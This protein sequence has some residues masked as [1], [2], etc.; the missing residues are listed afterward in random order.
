M[1]SAETRRHVRRSAERAFASTEVYDLRRADGAN[2]RSALEAEAPQMPPQ[3]SSAAGMVDAA[4]NRARQAVA[5]AQEGSRAAGS[6]SSRV[7][8]VLD[9]V[10]QP[11]RTIV[12]RRM[13]ALEERENGLG[14]LLTPPGG[15]MARAAAQTGRNAAAAASTTTRISAGARAPAAA[16]T[17]TTLL[18]G[19]RHFTAAASSD[20][21]S[22]DSSDG[23]SDSGDSDSMVGGADAFARRFPPRRSAAAGG[24]RTTTPSLRGDAASSDSGAR[25]TPFA[26]PSVSLSRASRTL[27]LMRQRA[28]MLQLVLELSRQ[29]LELNLQ[30]MRMEEELEL[31]VAL[32]RSLAGDDGVGAGPVKPKG[33]TEGEIEEAA[34]RQRYSA[35]VAIDRKA[36]GRA[37]CL[38]GGAECVICQAGLLPHESVRLLQCRHT[39]HVDCI[40]NW[41][42]RSTC[43]PLCRSCVESPDAAE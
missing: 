13:A 34:P 15:A 33:M 2:A 5:D 43:C 19:R 4:I 41:L 25:L 6:L 23:G 30:R 11:E 42:S 29:E 18:T 3:R 36:H 7:Q 35:A 38:P 17:T 16:A 31:A 10:G 8:A 24:E 27:D 21:S 26:R 40:D 1:R 12:Q 37:S 9:S 28:S 14:R 20:D 39:F 22:G 32:S